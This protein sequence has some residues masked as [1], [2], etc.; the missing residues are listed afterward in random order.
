MQM[1]VTCEVQRPKCVPIS[2]FILAQLQIASDLNPC[3]ASIPYLKLNIPQK[4][5]VPCTLILLPPTIDMIYILS[6]QNSHRADENIKKKIY[7]SLIWL[8][9][10]L[11]EVCLNVSSASKQV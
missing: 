4:N 11:I 10:T 5:R 8:I 1:V 9:G 6:N 3:F 7:I 2:C